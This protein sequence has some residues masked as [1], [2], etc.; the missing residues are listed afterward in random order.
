M[1]NV[2]LKCKVW[3]V[4]GDILKEKNSISFVDM[5]MKMEVLS[6]KDYEDW[7]FNRIPYLE[8]VCKTNLHKLSLIMKEIRVYAEEHQLKPSLTAYYQWGGKGKRIPLRFS[9]YGDPNIEKAYATHFFAINK[10]DKNFD[11]A[12]KD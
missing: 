5:L 2:E 10:T 11:E 12:E 4:A 8:K 6:Y 1:N 7:R 3:S 9:K